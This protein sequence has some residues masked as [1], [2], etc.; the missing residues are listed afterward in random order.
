MGITSTVSNPKYVTNYIE[1]RANYFAGINRPVTAEHIQKGGKEKLYKGVENLSVTT[2]S[3][4]KK[5]YH[6]IFYSSMTACVHQVKE[7]MVLHM[8]RDQ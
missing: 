4:K 6:I 8:E 7:L 1:C 5:T 3:I 2:V